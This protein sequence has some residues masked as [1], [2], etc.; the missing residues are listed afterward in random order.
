M[1]NVCAVKRINGNGYLVPERRKHM[2]VQVAIARKLPDHRDCFTYRVPEV[3]QS[4]IH[5]GSLVLVPVGR[6]NQQ[7][8]GYVTGYLEENGQT[9]YKEILEVLEPET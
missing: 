7:V 3:L 4:L 8:N 9:E 6:G 1:D 5:W 2:L